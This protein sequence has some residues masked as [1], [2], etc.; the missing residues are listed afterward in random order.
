MD[1]PGK[2]RNLP[3]Y[4][5]PAGLFYC[6]DLSY[7]ACDETPEDVPWYGICDTWSNTYEKV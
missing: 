5:N 4:F 3:D 1:Q 2:S 7:D 6:W